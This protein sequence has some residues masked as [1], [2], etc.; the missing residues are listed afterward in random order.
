[1]WKEYTYIYSTYSIA[2]NYSIH[3]LWKVGKMRQKHDHQHRPIDD[4]TMN[5]NDSEYDER[6]YVGLKW[7]TAKYIDSFTLI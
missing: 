2:V 3:K 4:N 7:A 1:M 6:I 5:S